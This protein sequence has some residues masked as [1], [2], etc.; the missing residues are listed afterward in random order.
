MLPFLRR[1]S[2]IGGFTAVIALIGPALIAGAPA[3]RP[4]S[5]AVLPAVP[6]SAAPLAAASAAAAALAPARAPAGPISLPVTVG[7]DLRFSTLTPDDGLS[8]G[9]VFGVAQDDKGFMWFATGDG[10]S[11]FDGYSLR[12]YR[13]E[14]GNPD[15]LTSNSMTAIRRGRGGVLWLGT[16]SG[17]VDRFDPTT[18]TFTHYRHDPANPKSLSGNSIAKYGLLE[19]RD[20]TLW[21]GTQD[22]GLNRLDPATGTFTRYGHEPAN[23]ASLSSNAI[24]NVYRDAAGMIW[25]GTSGEGLNRLDPTTGR[26]TRYLPDPDNPQALP[27]GVVDGVYEDRSGVFWVSTQK[28]LT[29]LDRKTGRFTRYVIGAGRAD[30]AALNGIVEMRE[31][32]TGN[33]WLGTGGAGV[34]KL[35]PARRQV[36]MY[37]K[38]PADPNTLLNNF[39]GGLTEDRSGVMWIGTLGGGVSRFSTQPAKFLHYKHEPDNPN[40]V[41]DNFILSIFEDSKGAVWVGNDRTLNRWD[42]RSN[43]WRVYRND[44]ADRTSISDG[45][46]T[47]TVE[48]PD[49]TLWFGTFFGGLSRLDPKTGRFTSYRPNPDDPRSLGDDGVRSLYRDRDGDIWVGGWNNGVSRLD[50]RTGQFQQFRPDPADPTTVS[51]GSVTDIYRDRENTLWVATEGGGLN[52]LDPSTGSFRHYRHAADKADSLP[53]DSVRVLYEDSAG[54]FWV[55][56]VGGL[57][58]F[59]RDRGTCTVYT[60]RE[61]LPNNTVEGILEDNREGLWISTN[62]GLSRFDPK[63]KTF[64]NYDVAD[65][66]QSNE[67]NVFT[68]FYKSP[69]TGEM[70]FGGINGFNVFHPDRV[71]DDTFIPPVVLTEFRLFGV[72][73]EVGG[74]SLLAKNIGELGSLALRYNQNSLAIGFSALAYVAPLKNRY[75]Y[76][77]KGFDAG[78]HSAASTE[79][80]AVYTN[81]N[82]GRYVFHVQGAN[83]DGVWNDEG[84]TLEI[85]I[86]P[87]WWGTWWLRT[88]AV[89]A[90]IALAAGLYRLRLAQV[91]RRNRELERH[92]DQKTSELREA[93]EA[94]E[95]FSYSV[96]HDLRAPLRHINGFVNLLNRRLD[97]EQD[98][99]A[100]HYIEAISGATERMENMIEDLLDFSKMSRA[101][102]SL[103][104]VDMSAVVRQVIAD[105]GPDAGDRQIRWV[106]GELPPVFGDAALLHAVL[107]NLVLNAVKFTRGRDVAVIEIGCESRDEAQA[108]FYV[109]DNGAG[110]DDSRA[111]NL[112]GVF[113]RL[114]RQD[115]FEGTGVGLATVRRIINRH[116][117]RIWAEAAVDRGA[118]FRFTLPVTPVAAIQDTRPQPRLTN[119]SR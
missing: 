104:P 38:N 99:L 82:P 64:R 55:G 41:A 53:D 10:L 75:R 35:D 59:D 7:T 96:S 17:G 37:A 34:L 88:L 15:S 45:S 70:Y 33:L 6:L 42:R 90:L 68:S 86:S 69:R 95:A 13:S 109:R 4:A 24:E 80:L 40:S 63:A 18:E 47:A 49:G 117:G 25:A 113:Q 23:P 58:A 71:N 111:D 103:Q 54:T 67:F 5:A 56:T 76:M 105:C 36:T 62:H 43:T 77:L 65:G 107:S 48:D 83:H 14:R 115:E 9:S 79:R 44:P 92:V 93:N 28:G 100:D 57:C 112:F 61:G 106:V 3:P 91:Y 94:L 116:G 1:Y 29:S 51:A 102:L 78:W 12:V 66:L 72:P 20:G 11:R 30:T 21:V 32:S 84:A 22:S 26:V 74:R 31:D 98:G 52:R 8:S 118:T 81:L 89:A 27:D 85:E 2:A 46:V 19:E 87:P 50:R 114:H 97:A 16:T 73:Q 60:E 101:E 110:F 39:V 108:V 119:T